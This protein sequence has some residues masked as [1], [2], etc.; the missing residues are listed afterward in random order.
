[1]R[2]GPSLR[3]FKTPS[4]LALSA[5]LLSACGAVNAINPFA[6]KVVVPDCPQI[7]LLKDADHMTVFRKGPGRDISDVV[8]ETEIKGFKGECEYVGDPGGYTEVV[9]NLRVSFD[10]ILGPAARGRE[11]QL[12]YFIAVPD[13]FPR[14]DGKS[15]FSAAVKF[16]PRRNRVTFTDDPLEIKIPLDEIRKGSETKVVI[17]LALSRDQ[18]IFNRSDTKTRLRK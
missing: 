2:L 18:L 14:T 10:M 8:F 12:K 3:E 11:H 15:G 5:V 6:D 17:S 16:P 1:L 7:G 13:F 4:F 9:L